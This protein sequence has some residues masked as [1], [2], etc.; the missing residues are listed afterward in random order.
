MAFNFFKKTETADLI[1][2]N[3]HIFPHGHPSF[4]FSQSIIQYEKCFKS[5]FG[6]G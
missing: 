4:D 1:L 6:D 2:H 5:F 3:G